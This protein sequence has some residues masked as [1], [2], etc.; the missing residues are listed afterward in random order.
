MIP[1]FFVRRLSG[2]VHFHQVLLTENN[3]H[4]LVIRFTSANIIIIISLLHKKCE[5]NKILTE[6]NRSVTD[7]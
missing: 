6:G 4:S 2:S 3:F 1:M 5:D 7:S